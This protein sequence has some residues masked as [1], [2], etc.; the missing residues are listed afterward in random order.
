MGVLK[1][2]LKTQL[3]V[4]FNF[5]LTWMFPCGC[6]DLIPGRLYEILCGCIAPLLFESCYVKVSRRTDGQG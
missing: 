5:L 1:Y 3:P 4:S 2:P 6:Q